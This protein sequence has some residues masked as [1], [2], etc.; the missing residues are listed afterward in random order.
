VSGRSQVV[1]LLQEQMPDLLDRVY[2]RIRMDVPF[3]VVGGVVDAAELRASLQA[4][5]EYVLSGLLGRDTTDFT[6]PVAT[7]RARA[8]QG[9]SLVEMLAAYRA[10]FAE[11]WTALVKA[12]RSLP[13]GSDAML[14]DIAGD[15]FRLHRT[16]AD[17][18]VSGY[19]HE[20]REIVRSNQREHSALVE[21]VL[22]DSTS[23]SSFWE[24]AQAL[25][26]PLA[27]QFLVVAAET[28][29]LGRDPLPR[30]E[31]ALAALD[32]SSV[33]R[34]QPDQSV[35]VVTLRRAAQAVGV[36]GTLSRHAVA[37]VGVSPV[38]T[39]LRQ[40]RCGLRLARLA[41]EHQGPGAGVEQFSD[42]PL[43]MLVASAPDAAL[44]AARSV[45]GSL[46]D[47]RTEDRDLLISTL[48][49]WLDVDGSASAAGT[50]LSVHPNT[51][52]YRLRRIEEATGRSLGA[53]AQLAELV[54]AVRAWT[55]LPTH[56]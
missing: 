19:R 17:A 54:T 7:G 46:L 11:I 42:S 31:P 55:E 38:F 5:I 45:L 24:V 22:A 53:P 29:E 25:R 52:R 23:E 48:L 6:A 35:G 44:D 10:A 8:G 14:V 43:S 15:L 1:Q 2:T 32:V 33:W 9:A 16:Y 51:V 37:R 4:N 12:A 56:S 36:L 28:V 34:L 50:A 39:R 26:L 30:V 13:E 47:L 20:Y 40:A 41:L 27:G 18:S 21:A 3:Y 49:T